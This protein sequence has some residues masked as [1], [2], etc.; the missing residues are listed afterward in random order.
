LLVDNQLP[1]ALARFLASRGECKHVLDIGLAESSD[2]EIWRYACLNDCVV[3][4]KDADF[5]H[6]A[7][8]AG[9]TGRLVWIR[10]GNCRNK[11]LLAAM[12]TLWP[13]VE[14]ALAAGDRIVE[15]R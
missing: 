7:S 10:I 14:A 8:M 13:K 4:S 1:V 15:L 9:S 2:T 6:L 11:A 3:V 5:L 12:E